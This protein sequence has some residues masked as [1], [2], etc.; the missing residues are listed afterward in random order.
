MVKPASSKCNFS[1]SYCFYKDVASHREQKSSAVMSESTAESLIKK[2]LDF[3]DGCAVSFMF[4]GGEPTLAGIDYFKFFTRRVKEK[5]IKNSPIYY[6]IQTN[7]SSCGDEWIRL[8]KENGFLVGLS[9]DGDEQA[10]RYRKKSGGEN[11]FETVMRAAKAFKES[12]VEFNILSVLTAESAKNGKR[13]YN[14]F[15]SEGFGYLQF[16]PCLKPFDGADGGMCMNADDYADFLCEVFPLY[17]NDFKN[18]KYISVRQ[19]D[20]WVRLYLG[21]RAEQCGM[22]GFCSHQFVCESDGKIY[23]CDFYCTDEYLLG[24][25]LTDGLKEMAYSDTAKRFITESYKVPDRCKKCEYY[26]LCRGGGCKRERL[27][28]DYCSAYKR[29]FGECLK[30]FK[31]FD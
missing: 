26:R 27:S 16:I 3:A 15:K 30:M 10:N 12:G 5:N 20:N 8:F 9:L 21:Q 19:F 31:A 17:V 7:G 13:I 29:F 2:A 14:F 4:Q 28:A 25:I 24:N 6:G 22:E 1:C 11:S 18:G 23:P